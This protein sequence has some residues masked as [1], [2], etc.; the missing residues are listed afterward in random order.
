M[1]S[2]SESTYV[3]IALQV[4]AY[5]SGSALLFVWLFT[6]P[7]SQL[8]IGLTAGSLSLTIIQP[9]LFCTILRDDMFLLF[10]FIILCASTASLVWTQSKLPALFKPYTSLY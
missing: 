9:I 2:E 1:V 8:S 5:S 4:F 3:H 10:E 7:R 6:N